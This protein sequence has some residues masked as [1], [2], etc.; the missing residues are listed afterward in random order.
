V[1]SGA[2]ADC[3]TDNLT[4]L[5]WVKDLNTVAIYGS[6]AGSA[7]TWQNALVSVTAMNT[8][9]YCGH[10]DWYLPTV[11][12]LSSLLN[13]GFIG[14][15]HKYQN[16]WLISQGFSNVQSNVYWSSSTDASN[17]SNAWSVN[18]ILGN[19]GA[20]TK[21]NANIYVWPVRLVP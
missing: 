18:F 10:T 6:T 14:G 7:T 11:N 5:M 21:T 17:I 4:G 3:I 13:D 12:D 8:T 19:V 15:A 16:E 1:G 20:F 2:E 9:G